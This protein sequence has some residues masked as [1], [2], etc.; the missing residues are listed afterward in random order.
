[1]IEFVETLARAGWG[2]FLA[3]L[4]VAGGFLIF[5][6]RPK[7]DTVRDAEPSREPGPAALGPR[8][9]VPGLESQLG[10]RPH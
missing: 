10:L 8:P 7:K 3:V 5:D 2:Y 4:L 1:M 6:R 9:A